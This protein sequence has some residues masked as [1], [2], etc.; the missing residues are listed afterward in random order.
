ML[1]DYLHSQHW[2]I[3]FSL[4]S[5]FCVALT[6]ASILLLRRVLDPQRSKDSRDVTA[7]IFSNLGSLYAVIVGFTIINAQERVNEIRQSVQQELACLEDL[8]RG[9]KIFLPDDQEKMKLSI[10][11]YITSILDKEWGEKTP[12][13]ETTQQYQTLL[14]MYFA[15]TID[16]PKQQIWYESAVD[17]L[18]TL[19]DLRQNRLFYGRESLGLEMWSVLILGGIC[20][21]IFLCFFGPSRPFLHLVMASILSMIIASSLFLIYFLDTTVSGRNKAL[22]EDIQ[23]WH[24]R[25][26]EELGL[27]PSLSINK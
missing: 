23:D 17:L 5:L 4:V 9:T 13:K 18:N 6:I 21:I 24:K 3:N 11:Y 7:V 19:S 15:A 25:V 14:S 12:H 2:T 26:S 8:Y 22:T 10:S 16:S 20:M 27:P 1:L